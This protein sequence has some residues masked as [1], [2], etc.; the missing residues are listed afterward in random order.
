MKPTESQIKEAAKE[1]AT[2]WIGDYDDLALEGRNYLTQAW[3]ELPPIN[4]Y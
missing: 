1:S 3:M 2:K 4:I